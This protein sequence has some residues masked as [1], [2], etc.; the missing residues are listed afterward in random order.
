VRVLWVPAVGVPRVS[1]L[2]V[3]IPSPG[4]TAAIADVA[5]DVV[6][7]A[8]VDLRHGVGTPARRSVR[9]R[10]WPVVCDELLGHHRAVLGEG[11]RRR[12]P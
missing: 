11:V 2:P 5:P 3:G 10:I 8:Q 1:S 6:H 12:A 4:M 7:L 9:Q